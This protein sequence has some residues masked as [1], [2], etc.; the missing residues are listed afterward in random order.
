[1]NPQKMEFLTQVKNDPLL[2]QVTEYTQRQ[3]TI[4]PALIMRQFQIKYHRAMCFIIYFEHTG[5]LVT[6]KRNGEM[7]RFVH[8]EEQLD[9]FSAT[10]CPS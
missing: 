5:L 7:V 9:M 10:H 6:G 2:N 4:T 1:M 8:N 3:R